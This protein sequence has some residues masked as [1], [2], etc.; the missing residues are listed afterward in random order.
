MTGHIST[1]QSQS[2]LILFWSSQFANENGD[3]QLSSFHVNDGS[4]VS[5]SCLLKSVSFSKYIIIHSKNSCTQRY[6]INCSGEARMKVNTVMKNECINNIC[7]LRCPKPLLQVAAIQTN[8]YSV[9][10]KRRYK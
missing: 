7:S 2:H 8:K 9:E 1:D 5:L 10:K 6:V 4:F 3:K